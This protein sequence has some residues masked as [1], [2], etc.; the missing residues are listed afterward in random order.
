MGSK[1]KNK[2]SEILQKEHPKKNKK[3]KRSG[4]NK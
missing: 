1:S 3:G 2:W 4:Y